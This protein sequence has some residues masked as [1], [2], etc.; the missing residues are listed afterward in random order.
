MFSTE[1][2][3]GLPNSY[4]ILNIYIELAWLESSVNATPAVI[5]SPAVAMAAEVQALGRSGVGRGF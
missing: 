3:T 1:M 2:P 4:I 5:L